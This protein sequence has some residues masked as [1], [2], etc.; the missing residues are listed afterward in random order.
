MHNMESSFF[1]RLSSLMELAS[2]IQHTFDPIE[3]NF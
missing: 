1:H 3:P 2:M